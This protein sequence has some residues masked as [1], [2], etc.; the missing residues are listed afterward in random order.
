MADSKGHHSSPR[1]HRMRSHS[2]Q[3]LAPVREPWV[4]I[5]LVCGL[6]YA[7]LQCLVSLPPYGEPKV[8]AVASPSRPSSSTFARPASTALRVVGT[9]VCMHGT[10]SRA[11][12]H[13]ALWTA[14]P[15]PFAPQ[16][17]QHELDARAARAVQ[18]QVKGA[19][20]GGGGR[21]G[22]IGRQCRAASER[23]GML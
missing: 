19:H 22:W 8:R 13:G 4:T 2:A 15:R 7:R 10:R 1:A 14:H 3:R 6:R 17:D 12:L 9:H 18:G 16:A 23:T 5:L 20:H 11:S 21:E